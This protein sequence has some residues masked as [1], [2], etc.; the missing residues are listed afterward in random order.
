MERA[1]DVPDL[2]AELFDWINTRMTER[3]LPA[4][5][6]A[7]LTHYQYATIHPY[8]DGNGRTARADIPAPPTL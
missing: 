1:P 4:P 3:D 8:Y 7:A 2:M 6:V 5:M